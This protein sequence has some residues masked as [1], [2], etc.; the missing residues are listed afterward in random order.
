[1]AQNKTFAHLGLSRARVQPRKG[2]KLCAIRRRE[3]ETLPP[4]KQRR[5]VLLLLLLLLL[6]Y[7]VV[8]V[9]EFTLLMCVPSLS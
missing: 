4:C 5:F 2:V 3:K 9:Y 8:A 6:V 1:M 7:V